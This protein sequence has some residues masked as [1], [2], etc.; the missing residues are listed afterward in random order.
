MSVDLD[1]DEQFEQHK[2]QYIINR[3]FN[4]ILPVI[5]QKHEL[6]CE[7][8]AF[9]YLLGGYSHSHPGEIPLVKIE[10]Q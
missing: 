10:E 9:G 3:L 5:K 4:E 7:L 1:S 8:E 6:G 2:R